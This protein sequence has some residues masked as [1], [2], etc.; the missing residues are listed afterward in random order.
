MAR[1]CLKCSF[2]LERLYVVGLRVQAGSEVRMAKGGGFYA[3]EVFPHAPR[4]VRK[5][6]REGMTSKNAPISA[7]LPDCD[8]LRTYPR[9]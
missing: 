3:G 9:P 8:P 1:R 5:I 4:P 6:E 7:K 2:A